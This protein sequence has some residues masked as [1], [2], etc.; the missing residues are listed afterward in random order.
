M[1]ITYPEIFKI[2]VMIWFCAS[3]SFAVVGNFLFWLWLHRRNVKMIFVLTGTPGYLDKVYI[4][5]CKSRG[6]RPNKKL[7]IFRATSF[8]S[9]I[10]SSIVAVFTVLK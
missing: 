8:V 4:E 9:A 1:Q 7:L 3:V 10:I 6:L 5:W 2:A